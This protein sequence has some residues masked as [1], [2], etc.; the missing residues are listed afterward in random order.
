MTES[1]LLSTYQDFRSRLLSYLAK[2]SSVD[3]AEDLLQVVL[4]KAWQAHERFPNDDPPQIAKWLFRISRNTLIDRYRVT[5]PPALDVDLFAGILPDDQ[6]IEDEV[7]L[8]E[9]C[10]E[11]NSHLRHLT[12]PQR[13]AVLLDFRDGLSARTAG[14]LAG[15]RDGAMRALRHRG[16]AKLRREMAASAL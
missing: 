16:L 2:G 4:M 11:I 15:K 7:L 3:E 5:P 1:A 13:Q 14:E 9:L 6:N 10:H 12:S 8:S